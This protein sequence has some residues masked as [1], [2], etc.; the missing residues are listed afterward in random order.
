[1]SFFRMSPF[2]SS[3]SPVRESLYAFSC[4]CRFMWRILEQTRKA[5][6]GGNTSKRSSNNWCVRYSSD[7]SYCRKSPRSYIP[8]GC[9]NDQS[10]RFLSSTNRNHQ[11]QCTRSFQQSERSYSE[12]SIS[13][14]FRFIDE[15]RE[16]KRPLDVKTFS[17]EAKTDYRL[18]T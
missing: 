15:M 5:N 17:N 16:D 8:S 7:P 6:R 18:R 10:A 1:M 4:V 12:T 3:L 2:S 11:H 9:R 13:W 14:Y